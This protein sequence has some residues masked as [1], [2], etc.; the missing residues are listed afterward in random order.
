MGRGLRGFASMS[1][2]KVREIASMGGRAAHA[3]GMAHEW[4]TEQARMAGRKGGLARARQRHPLNGT[5][6][7]H[8]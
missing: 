4:S 7:R 3:S 6:K 5:K 8:V 1:P 2:D